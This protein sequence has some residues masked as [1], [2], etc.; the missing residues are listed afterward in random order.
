MTHVDGRH[1]AKR[2]WF[3]TS[4]RQARRAAGFALKRVS[5]RQLEGVGVHHGDAG[6]VFQANIHVALQIADGLLR[7]AAN[8]NGADHR[9]ILGVNHRDLRG[10]CGREYRPVSV[11]GS[12]RMPSG[13]VCVVIFLMGCMVSASNM[14]TGLLLLN[15]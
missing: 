15:P 3:F 13:L 10:R 14:E 7:R 2:I 4:N 9:A 6:L 11:A 1:M 12:N 5:R 8:V